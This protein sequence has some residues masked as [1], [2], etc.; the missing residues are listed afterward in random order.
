MSRLFV[1]SFLV[2]TEQLRTIALATVIGLLVP[3]TITAQTPNLPADATNSGEPSPL[4]GPVAANSDTQQ[5]SYPQQQPQYPSQTSDQGKLGVTMGPINV[6]FRGILLL[7][8]SGSDS[9]VAGGDLPLWASSANANFPDGSSG[10]THDLFITARQTVLGFTISPSAPP[11]SGWTPSAVVEFD[12]FGSRPADNNLP[13]GRV[14]N[15]PRLRLAYFQLTK[16]TWKFVAGQDKVIIAPLDPISFSHVAAPLGATAGNLWGWLPQ[17]RVEKTQHLSEK[18]TALFQVGVLRPEFADPRLGDPLAPGNG[19]L[20]SPTA[21]TRSTMPFF[22]AR[23][24]LS[25][26]M[27][28]STATVG[29]GGHYGREVAGVNRHPDS[30]ASALDFRIPVHSRLILRGEGYAG[31]N[32]I[33]FQGGIDQGVAVVSGPPFVIHKIGDAGGWGELTVRVTTDDKNHL[34]FGAGTDDPVVHTLL[35]N[36]GRSKNTFYWASYFRK[37]TNDVTM[38]LEWSN[39]QFRTIG[40]TGGGIVPGPRNP[41]GRA[42]VLNL[43]FAYTF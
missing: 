34:Y 14:F 6:R 35:M 21:G 5:P 42:N 27:N 43:A 41:V 11:A 39:W 33:P 32:L 16:G 17:V 20:D 26:P 12:F 23:A 25:H 4:A 31:S 30:W 1:R 2:I 38:A 15:Q 3:H 10:R 13:Q 7:N 24:A 9:G 8:L 18:T 37:L 19:S 22:Q 29:V 40:F 36:S 28:G